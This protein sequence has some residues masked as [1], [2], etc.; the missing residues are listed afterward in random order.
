MFSLSYFKDSDMAATRLLMVRVADL[1]LLGLPPRL[2]APL[3]LPVRKPISDTCRWPDCF[4]RRSYML[5][6]LGSEMSEIA[7]KDCNTYDNDS[8]FGDTYNDNKVY[9]TESLLF[10]GF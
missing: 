8:G 4:V 2:R 5:Y 9:V 7:L 1:K 6:W 10:R 3:R